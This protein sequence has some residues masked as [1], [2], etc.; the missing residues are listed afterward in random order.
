MALFA[1]ALV[2]GGLVPSAEGGSLSRYSEEAMGT[3]VTLSIWEADEDAPRAAAAALAEFSRIDALMTDWD[4]D[5]DVSRINQAAGEGA[6]QVDDEVFSIIRRAV[7]AS[8]KTGG[9]FDVTVGAFRGL[10]RFDEDIEEAVPPDEDIEARAELVD[11][12]RIQLGEDRRISLAEDGMRITLGGIAKGYAVDRAVSI[13]R[14]RGVDDFVLQAGGDLY[15]SGTRGPRAWRVGVRDPRGARHAY[16]AVAELEDAAFSTSGD[17][18]RGFV[19]D[20]ERYHH[21]LDPDTG[22]PA[23]SSRSVT[24]LADDALT[25]DIWSTA[26]FVM[27]PK[28]GLRRAE[29]HDAID[30]VFVGADNEVHVTSGLEDRLHVLQ[31]P[32]DAP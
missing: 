4:E 10:W 25:A 3:R 24:V 12:E 16:F 20:G 26:L 27:G 19:K 22:R 5:S 29:E 31:P 17:Y 13:L 7:S 14:E 9:A 18:E 8:R 1:G 2:T 21:I 28:D 11:Y 15:V 6:A 32:T 23:R 30:A